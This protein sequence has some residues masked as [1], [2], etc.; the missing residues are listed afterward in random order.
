LGKWNAGHFPTFGSFP[1]PPFPIMK[2]ALMSCFL[3]LAAYG[4]TYGQLTTL[5]PPATAGYK[6]VGK[7]DC[8]S[9][10][11]AGLPPMNT[12]SQKYSNGKQIITISLTEYP[13]G[14]PTMV[15]YGAGGNRQGDDPSAGAH[16][17]EKLVVG[18][19]KGSVTFMKQTKLATASLTVD[20]T[21]LL[22]V[23]GANQP[24]AEAVKALAKALKL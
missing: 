3:L 2:R 23:N 9:M 12:C 1:R 22:D 17:Y 8:T 14:N 21:L 15:D 6:P 24:D 13:K 11:M 10:N 19:A 5:F 18:R 20:N 4:L 7:P 16:S